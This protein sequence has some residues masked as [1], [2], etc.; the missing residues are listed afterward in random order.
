[1]EILDAF[2]HTANQ[3]KISS[4]AF[5]R[6]ETTDGVT[7]LF[8]DGAAK[9]ELDSEL[10]AVI[11]LDDR[12]VTGWMADYRR[13]EFW[14]QPSFGKN[15]SDIPDQT[16]GLIYQTEDGL[17]GAILPV[18]SEQY[19]CVLKGNPE[20]GVDARLFS[21]CEGMKT[22]K[23]LALVLAE[24]ENP[25]ELLHRCAKVGVGLLNNG[26][27]LREERR[28]PEVFRYLGWCS[29][30]AFEI[31]VDDESLI[32][33]CEEFRQKGIPVRWMI[34]DDMWATVK[35]F[36][37]ATYETREKMFELMHASRLSSF[38]ADPKRFPKGLKSCI[39][40]IKEY[41]ITVG[42]WHPTTGYWLG[43]DPDGEIFEKYRDLLIK[44]ESGAYIP[45]YEQTKAYAFYNAFH[46]YLRES[47]A[48]F[49]KIDNQSMTRRFYKKYAPV[50]EV[51]R[52]FHNAMEASVG[53]HFDNAMINCMGM[54]NE[55]M[56]NRS[57][58]PISRCSNDFQP[59]NREWFAKHILQCSYN[60][61]IQGQ[62]YHCDWDMWWTDD[63]QGEKNSL[64]RAIS[65][66]PIYI[67]DTIHRSKKDLLM[68]LCMDDGE[69][70]MC[71]KPA[72]PAR[73][74][75]FENPTE[76][77]KIF[78]LQNTANGCGVITAFN[79]NEQNAKTEGTVSPADVED[80]QGEEFAV[81]EH[82]SGEFT[83]L[84]RDERLPVTL[85]DNDDYRLYIIV[86]LTDGSG[87]IGRT[88]KY[89]SPRTLE[90]RKDGSVAPLTGGRYA[91][92]ENRTLVFKEYDFD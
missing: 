91:L 73:D 60:S 71:D 54:A 35:D 32:A 39:G 16:Q 2:L 31:R 88:D 12:R 92:A 20:G 9:E 30:D 61:M 45:T 50:G 17:Y 67:S 38:E 86:P 18:V 59:E 66:G 48:E 8:F 33:K 41:G 69:I 23:A 77:G 27:R 56:W 57:V 90:R 1:M 84:K 76:S 81:Y 24:G 42:M 72:M 15:L 52:Q 74:C 28:Y 22:C 79:L 36:Y 4:S 13:Y 75:L 11:H 68:K 3:N 83:C 43:I 89:I 65:G 82:F 44:T 37:G 53:Q 55:D 29:W 64:L 58:S 78:K 34:I 40:R 25:Y 62:F 85:S 70:L 87:W 10:G 14:C 80:L 21:W 5:C 26:C 47:G 49:V 46:D 51:A 19:K 7:A 6:K 63:G